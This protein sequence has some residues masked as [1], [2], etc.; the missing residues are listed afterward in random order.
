MRVSQF[1]IY[2]LCQRSLEALGAAYGI[3][4]DGAEAVVWLEARGLPGLALL[5]RDLPA[6]EKPGAFAGLMGGPAAGEAKLDAGGRPAIVLLGGVIDFLRLQAA[7]AKD[8]RGQLILQSCL[9][10][11]TLL[12]AAHAACERD[13]ELE[14]AWG[15]I[16]ARIG[17]K[18]LAI[19]V[20]PGLDLAEALSQ[21]GPFAVRLVLALAHG[22]GKRFAVPP[23]LTQD[24]L[25]EAFVRSLGE[26]VEVDD[27]LWERLSAIA[28]RVQVPASEVSRLKGA[29]GGDANA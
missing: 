9:S 13:D 5:A 29:G 15:G 19:A 28:A 21:A 14:I 25:D 23:A 2:R 8:R 27:A 24:D 7:G 22:S 1:E 6:L 16:T 10:P 26:G 12:P 17:A 11:L 18:R 3:D 20:Q 4:R